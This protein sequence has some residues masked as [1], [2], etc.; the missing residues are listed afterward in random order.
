MFALASLAVFVI[1]VSQLAPITRWLA[2]FVVIPMIIYPYLKRFTPLCHFW[3]GAVDGLAPVG[4]WVAVTGHFDPAAWVLG[5][6]VACWIAGFDIIYATMDIEIDRA[7]GL[8]SV[9]ADYGIA[10]ALSISRALHVLSVIAMASVGLMLGLGPI[11]AIGVVAVAVLLAYEQQLVSPTD[12]SR[13]NMAFLSVNGVIAVLYLGAVSLDVAL[14]VTPPR[15]ELRG[16]G[17]AYG[18]RVVLAGVERVLEPGRALGLLGP[19]GSGKSTL[20]RCIAGPAAPA[21]GARARRR[22]GELRAA[23]GRA[24]AR[25]LRGSPPAALGRAERAREPRCCA[26]ASTASTRTPRQQRSR[27]PASRIRRDARRRRSRRAS[28][29]A[30][31]WPAHCC[32]RRQLLVLDEPHSGLDEASS[33]RLD[34]VLAGLRRQRHADPRDA[35][36][37]ARRAAVRRAH[38]AR[39]AALSAH[40]VP[41][42]RA[43]R[44]L[45][46][47]DI[48]LERRAPQ[49]ALAMAPVRRRRAGRAALR[50]RHRA[51]RRWP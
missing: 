40:P 49:L 43:V 9:P 3:L 20:L 37:R 22:S 10:R 28:G 50:R 39:G 33:A 25:R 4:G 14:L 38:A 31:R 6:A 18:S 23:A 29:S 41:F 45:V 24:R 44:L 13:V 21:R 30:W 16:V 42:A 7:Q 8:H 27:R 19:N 12:L 1:G 46:R 36:A 48:V 15:L 26:P 34:A 35:R 2:P 51:S 47:T 11:Y 17:H 32:P 5:V